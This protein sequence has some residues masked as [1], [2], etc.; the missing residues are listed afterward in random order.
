M[1]VQA[2]F[3]TL[4]QR[5]RNYAKGCLL[6]IFLAVHIILYGGF[7]QKFC[8]TKASVRDHYMRQTAVVIIFCMDKRHEYGK[9]RTPGHVPGVDGV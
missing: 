2:N 6:S 1:P 7:S 3:H 4:F 5:E 8:I 9:R